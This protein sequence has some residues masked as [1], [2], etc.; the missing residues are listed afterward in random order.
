[1]KFDSIV[2]DCDGVLIDSEMLANRSEVELLKSIGIEFDLHEYM[3]RF[4]GKTK[5]DVLAG[6]ESLHGVKLT[7][8]FWKSVED[9][10]FKVFQTELQPIAGIFELLDCVDIA[11]CVASSSSLE[12]LD[13]TLKLTGLFDRFSPHIFSAEQVNRGKPAPDLFLFA[14]AQMQVPPVGG[15]AQKEHRCVVIEDSLA[16]VRAGVAAGM[17]VLGFTGGSHIQ[18]GHHAKLLDAGAIEVFSQMSQIADWL[19]RAN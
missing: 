10:T 13:L 17:T 5:Q 15:A 6:I 2:F 8:D 3:A 1:M 16:G 4:V 19:D 12:R 7:E 11:K 18:P 14:A 9:N